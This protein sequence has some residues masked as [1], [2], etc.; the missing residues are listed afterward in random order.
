MADPVLV[1]TTLSQSQIRLTWTLPVNPDEFHVEQS[2]S[3]TGDWVD[4]VTVDGAIRT[5][6]VS[7]LDCGTPYYFRVRA[8]TGGSYGNYSNIDDATT[9]A[10]IY[11]QGPVGV[12]EIMWASP[13][14]TVETARVIG[15]IGYDYGIMSAG[16]SITELGMGPVARL[17]VVLDN[18]DGRYSVT[19]SAS[20]A[21][22]NGLYQHPMR[23][24]AGY[25]GSTGV[26]FMGRVQDIIYDEKAATAT[27]TCHGYDY[28]L[29]QQRP[30]TLALEDQR[31]DELIASLATGMTFANQTLERAY[32]V[33]PW[34][35]TDSDDGMQEIRELAECEGGIAWVNPMTG[36]LEYWAWAHWLGVASAATV[37]P[38]NA[39]NA[40]P[41][42]S[43]A[44]A[45]DVV[46]VTYT[47]RRLG[48][49]AT[50]HQLTR[51]V[52]IAPLSTTKQRM[53]FRSPLGRLQAYYTRART[54]GGTNMDAALTVGTT[55]PASATGWETTLQNTDDELAIVVD[56]WDVVGWPLQGLPNREYR[57][58][59]A[60]SPALEVSRRHDFYPGQEIGPYQMRSRYSMQTEVQ[61]KLVGD[62]RHTRLSGP[63]LFVE[64]GP[65]PGDI[66]LNVGSVVTLTLTSNT[67][68]INTDFVLVHRRG[69]YG[70][71]WEETW[72][73][74]M[75]DDLYDYVTWQVPSGNA[76]YLKIG[77]SQLN[78]GRLGY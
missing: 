14:Y 48:R 16:A 59:A 22:V 4:I 10:C 44:D 46:N 53:R 58:E 64:I 17:T 52:V 57:N 42:Y 5:G 36:Y 31:T 37:T 3:G 38:A 72:Q 15:S 9:L 30:E 34:H 1:A 24:T 66:A 47:S 20:Q 49:L 61:A 69:S 62:L 68:A 26:I 28:D 77:T 65:V 13:A 7:S 29:V 51:P 67:T 33:V 11:A 74:V 21:Y 18:H 56:R 70:G 60:S 23:F 2:P 12:F 35:Y 55:S 76:G 27:L 75:R 39:E 78:A 71:R 43:F 8:K 41:R 32:C 73:A 25:G 19:K 6:Y 50:V 40:K 54:S 63:P 45:R